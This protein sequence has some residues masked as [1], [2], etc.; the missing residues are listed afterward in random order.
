MIPNLRLVIV[1]KYAG[2]RTCWYRAKPRACVR[3]HVANTAPLRHSRPAHM[4]VQMLK[5]EHVLS[6]HATAALAE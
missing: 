5:F 4:L 6:G 3:R 2:R 1:A